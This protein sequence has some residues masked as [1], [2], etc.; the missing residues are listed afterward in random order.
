MRLIDLERYSRSGDV[1]AAGEDGVGVEE[2]GGYGG[3]EAVV[4]VW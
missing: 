2:L 4:Y 3:G 1:G